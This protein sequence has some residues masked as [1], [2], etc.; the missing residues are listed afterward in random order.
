MHATL[1]IAR[2]DDFT[3]RPGVSTH[4]PGFE[5][6]PC[7]SIVRR[8]QPPPRP[9]PSNT[10]V[11]DLSRYVGRTSGCHPVRTCSWCLPRTACP[12]QA[13]SS[14][15]VRAAS[16]RQSD[17]VTD[18]SERIT[19][20]PS[21]KHRRGSSG[22]FL[23]RW[24][25]WWVSNPSTHADGREEGVEGVQ[26]ALPRGSMAS[27][28]RG[29]WEEGTWRGSP[30]DG[31]IDG[32]HR[33]PTPTCSKTQTTHMDDFLQTRSQKIERATKVQDPVN[34]PGSRQ[35]A[36]EEKRKVSP[37]PYDP[38]RFPTVEHGKNTK[39][40]DTK[41]IAQDPRLRALDALTRVNIGSRKLVVMFVHEN[42]RGPRAKEGQ[43]RW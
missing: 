42:G 4:S 8:G 29:G 1:S 19:L 30:A 38:H 17:D 13:S 2:R 33:S 5:Q 40:M 26:R 22:E 31:A 20:H 32:S 14:S 43:A 6:A 10:S 12:S 9:G 34:S 15:R 27:G 3:P 16:R 23:L 11:S 39:P 36:R 28:I 37:F 35:L 18:G 25:G 24:G 7:R 21:T 41:R